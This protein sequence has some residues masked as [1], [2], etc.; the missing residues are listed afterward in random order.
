MNNFDL[1]DTWKELLPVNV[2]V[3]GG[4]VSA[5]LDSLT[6]SELLS[7]GSADPSRVSELECGRMY[8]KQA[9]RKLGI[10]DVELP[11]GRNRAPVWPGGTIGSISHVQRRSGSYCFAAVGR[12]TEISCLGIDMEYEH[13]LHPSVWASI[14]TES[15]L[16]QI[17]SLP[18][19]DRETE[20][21]SRWSMKEAIAKAALQLFEPTEIETERCHGG[22][23]FAAICRLIS[24]DRQ[25]ERRWLGRITR[26][27]GLI[28]T[29]VALPSG[30]SVT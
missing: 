18:V 24:G 15:E 27:N 19:V 28:L 23:S 7:V 1:T 16:T 21:L 2:E 4:P 5:G 25:T 29:A 13:G 6:P 26:V 8:A 30:Q 22:D 20:V 14:L 9:L 10:H 11:V 3:A 12:T 17:C